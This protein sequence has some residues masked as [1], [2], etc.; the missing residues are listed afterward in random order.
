MPDHP[1]RRRLAPAIFAGVLALATA[2]LVAALGGVAAPSPAVARSCGGAADL[3]ARETLADAA[4]A[5]VCEINRE[6]RAR[7]L[8]ALG[9]H[10]ELARAGDRHA[11]DMVRRG[12]F[13]HVS[14]GGRTMAARLRAAG[15]TDRGIPWAAGE[16]LAWGSGK[17]ATPAGTVAAWMRSAPHR[18]VLLDRRYRDV[19]VGVAL[20]NPVGAGG[21][22]ATYSAELGVI[23]R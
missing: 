4:A 10:P 14:P 15:Y 19:G 13:S 3:P 6:R 17:R 16:V 7:E 20:G 21:V 5:V 23:A 22:S 2:I 9:A 18:D 1:P 12:F 8:P 11:A